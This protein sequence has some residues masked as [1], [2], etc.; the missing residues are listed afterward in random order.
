MSDEKFDTTGLDKII[1]ALKD[2]LPRARVGILGASAIRGNQAAKPGKSLNAANARPKKIDFTTNAA[3]GAI[4]EFGGKN[5]PQRS[6][7]RV[8]I[9]EHLQKKMENAGAF[10]KE[11]LKEVVKSGSVLPWVK[12]IAVLAEGI[13]AEAFATGGY[14]KWPA[15]APGYTNAGNRLLVDTGQLRDSITSEVK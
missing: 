7:L 8:P 13:V 9:A 3:I 10:S 11:E 4:H 5:M 2:S 14:G 6:F 1:K 15:H 12:K